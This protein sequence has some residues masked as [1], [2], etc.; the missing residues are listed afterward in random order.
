MKKMAIITGHTNKAKGAMLSE[1]FE[2]S[3]YEYNKVLASLILLY[4]LDLENVD[5]K[6]FFRDGR[7][8]RN[9]YIAVERWGADCSVEL[10]F[11]SYTGKAAGSCVLYGD[12][13][14]A[15]DFAGIMQG[16]LVQTMGNRDRGI[17]QVALS[18]RGGT[19][20]CS[21]GKVPRILIEP[22]FGSNLNDSKRL[23]ALSQS[24]AQNILE[25]AVQ[26]IYS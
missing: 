7:G 2:I 9:T 26:F 4:S 8:I 15:K 22:G 18:D 5:V 14:G 11:N 13:P 16:K 21:P 19:S 6:L 3:E 20:L 23:L 17:K 12:K 24:L 25:G 10:H 1:P